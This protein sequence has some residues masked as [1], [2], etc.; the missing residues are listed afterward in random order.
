MEPLDSARLCRGKDGDA[1]FEILVFS[2]TEMN[3]VMVNPERLE[4]HDQVTVHEVFNEVAYLGGVLPFSLP[5]DVVPLRHVATD[6]K[7]MNSILIGKKMK[8]SRGLWNL[9]KRT[10]ADRRGE[11]QE[12]IKVEKEMRF[13][14]Q[15]IFSG[16]LQ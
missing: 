11:F 4:N 9:P 16:L 5:D 2:E 12:L 13:H 6:L 10:D 3:V 1:G 15:A 14:Y 8:I 7:R